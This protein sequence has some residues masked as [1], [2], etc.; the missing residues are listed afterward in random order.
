MRSKDQERQHY[1]IERGGK[2]QSASC[3]RSTHRARTSTHHCALSNNATQVPTNL[4][5]S[6]T[7]SQ[8]LASLRT[9]PKSSSCCLLAHSIGFLARVCIIR[10]LFLPMV[11]SP[12]YRPPVPL[13]CPS[14][15]CTLSCT[16]LS[17]PSH[18][19]LNGSSLSSL[20]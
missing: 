17:C 12:L 6:S 10:L 4:H 13:P 20:L 5:K 8:S 11:Q 9:V 1:L 16:G 2:D 14:I 7:T 18:A 15:Q 3:L 19:C